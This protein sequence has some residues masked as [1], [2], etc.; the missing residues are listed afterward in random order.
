MRICNRIAQCF[1]LVTFAASAACAQDNAVVKLDQQAYSIGEPVAI[2][3]V[4]GP[5]APASAV[6]NLAREGKAFDVDASYAPSGGTTGVATAMSLVGKDGTPLGLGRYKAKVVLNGKTYPLPEPQRLEIVPPGNPELHLDKFDPAATDVVQTLYWAGADRSA[7][8]PVNRERVIDLTLRGSGFQV[9]DHA[10]DNVIVINGSR[11][12]PEPTWNA[13]GAAD[14]FDES[15]GTE[16]SPRKDKLVSASVLSSKELHLCHVMV[17]A[18]GRLLVRVDIGDRASESQTFIVYSQ[19]TLSVALCSAVIAAVL[20]LIPVAMLSLM[21]GSYRIGRDNELRRRLLFLDPQTDTYSLSKLQFYLWTLAALFAYAY[22]FISKVFVQGQQW[23]DVPGTLPGVIAVS[24]GTAVGSQ[25]VT[26]A[27]GPKGAG[28]T[29]PSISDFIM[30]G[31]VVAADRVQMLLWTLAGV[32]GFVVAALHFAPGVIP[33]LPPVPENLLYL[34][35]LSSAGY[36]GGKMARKAGPV[37]DELS[38]EPSGPDS[39]IASATI[40]AQRPDLRPA[41]DQARAE[42]A[43]LGTPGNTPATT[44]VKA[45]T[46][47]IDLAAAAQTSADIDAL[48]QALTA[49]RLACEA[50]A[51]QAADAYGT[52]AD[53]Q[54]ASAAQDAGMAQRC[55]AAM[56][57]FSAAVTQAIAKASAAPMLAHIGAPSI[58]RTITIRGTSL[59][60]DGL[61]SID[62][63][64]LPFRMLL[65]AKGQQQPDIV[66]RDEATP[67]FAKLMKLTIDPAQ[68]EDADRLQ[69]SQWFADEGQHVFTL[70]N[71]DGQKADLEFSMPPGSGQKPTTGNQAQ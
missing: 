14:C 29:N 39:A 1:A 28:A 11:L 24:A 10:K 40:V 3:I 43:A 9:G 68:L 51:T 21:S 33:T 45:L 52:A 65:D 58:R 12:L 70:T 37:I 66:I 61:F 34:M 4:N 15:A 18:N 16:T 7:S 47:A 71:T 20:A 6:I 49:Q 42:L 41:T 50:A 44:A 36:L 60:P 8:S 69:V 54:K 46:Q 48:V 22:L 64:E 67:T 26:S 17:P 38:I 57:E 53:A 19:N 30:S 35:G 56:Q 62:R 13:D 63:V 5:A 59:S 27:K 32:V 23:P 55:A 25:I 2:S 31:G